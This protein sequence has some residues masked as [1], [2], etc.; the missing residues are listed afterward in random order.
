MNNEDNADEDEDIDDNDGD[1]DINN[2]IIDKAIS[3]NYSHGTRLFAV[4]IGHFGV[5]FIFPI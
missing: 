5:F 4:H 1:D 3:T 2:S